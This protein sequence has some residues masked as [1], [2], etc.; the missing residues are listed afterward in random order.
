MCVGKDVLRVCIATLLAA[1]GRAFAQTE[2]EFNTQNGELKRDDQVV[3]DFEGVAVQALGD[4]GGVFTWAVRGNM[5]VGSSVSVTFKGTNLARVYVGGNMHV[6]GGGSIVSNATGNEAGAGGGSGGDGGSGGN[7]GEG[8]GSDPIDGDA[9]GNGQTA[10]QGLGGLLPRRGGDGGEGNMGGGQGGGGGLSRQ[11]GANGVNGEAGDAGAAGGVGLNNT[12]AAALAGPGG[13][14][15]LQGLGG[16]LSAGGGPGGDIAGGDAGQGGAGG[17]GGRGF[18]GGDGQNGAN[19]NR[20]TPGPTVLAVLNGGN[21]GGGGGG[22]GGAGGGGEG[23]TGAGGGGGG[24]GSGSFAFM[25]TGGGGGGGGAGASGGKGGTGGLGASG[26]EGGG[27]G[28]G[29]QFVVLGRLDVDGSLGAK[30]GDFGAPSTGTPGEGG[31]AGGIG[32]QGGVGGPASGLFAIPG[33]SGGNGGNGG[34]GGEGGT[35]GDGGRGGG[36]TGGT[37][38]LNATLIAG[39]GSIDLAGGFGPSG[40]AHNG[41]V[42]YSDAMAGQASLSHAV[43]PWVVSRTM[44]YVPRTTGPYFAGLVSPNIVPV[45]MGQPSV[46]GGPGPFGVLPAALNDTAINA[47]VSNAP[48]RAALVALRFDTGPSGFEH[49][50]NAVSAVSSNEALDMVVLVNLRGEATP[51]VLNGVACASF[52]FDHWPEFGGDG[53]RVLESIGPGRAWAAFSPEA[54]VLSLD[55]G[56]ISGAGLLTLA[57]PADGAATVAYL[58]VCDPDMNQDGN[59]DQD[60]VLYLVNV[61][62]GGDNPTGIDPDFNGDGNVD[63]DDVSA[64]IDVVAGGSCP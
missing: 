61:I 17:P 27:G 3:H 26:G 21:G 32:G 29:V 23:T 37:V 28:G 48:S 53:L 19:A 39:A 30:G 14:A 11:F 16:A 47:A 60:D 35:G 64:V 52:A 42:L 38:F 8:G 18:D 40:Q 13:Q 33:G 6:L 62:G 2:Y 9:G 59:A 22:G 43:T 55:V 57:D 49:G 15:G 63:Q 20:Y 24:G 12:A 44:D 54:G 56:V 34:L 46:E 50:Y 7:E 25:S 36:G 58:I 45:V 51:A 31:A 4:A 5:I 41:R 10:I 1:S